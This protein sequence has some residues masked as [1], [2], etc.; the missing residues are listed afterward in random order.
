MFWIICNCNNSSLTASVWTYLHFVTASI[1]SAKAL[2]V[3][4]GDSISIL[5][6]TK[7]CIASNAANLNGLDKYDA[8][9]NATNGVS[10]S[11]GSIDSFLSYNTNSAVILSNF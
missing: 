1:T 6:I 2:N 7:V 10:N 11:W 3:C 8:L 5:N 4:D 9:N